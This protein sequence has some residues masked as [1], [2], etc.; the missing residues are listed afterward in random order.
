M[1]ILTIIDKVQEI[2]VLYS[3]QRLWTKNLWKCQI[4][5]GKNIYINQVFVW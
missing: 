4:H 3:L 5:C 1:K 2:Q